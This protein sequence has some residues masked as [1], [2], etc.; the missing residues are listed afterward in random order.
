MDPGGT[1]ARATQLKPEG[2]ESFAGRFLPATAVLQTRGKT[3]AIIA[4]GKDENYNPTKAVHRLQIEHE[5]IWLLH[6][7]E[8][9][10]MIRRIGYNECRAAYE[11]YVGHSVI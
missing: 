11:L 10:G 8:A 6:L 2:M 3:T 7:L 4:G 5:P 9:T 1:T